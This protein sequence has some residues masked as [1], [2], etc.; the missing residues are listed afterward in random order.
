MG[1]WQDWWLGGPPNPPKNNPT[2]EP[3]GKDGWREHGIHSFTAY[4]SPGSDS[5]HP[6]GSPEDTEK[7]RKQCGPTGCR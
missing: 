2:V 5:G 4:L 6:Q 3:W 1:F 7:L